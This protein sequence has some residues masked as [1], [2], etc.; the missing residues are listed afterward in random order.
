M[1]GDLVSRK[2]VI[3]ALT[4]LRTHDGMELSASIDYAEACEAI[5]DIPVVGATL[6][7]AE[8]KYLNTHTEPDGGY[9]VTSDLFPGLIGDGDTPNDAVDDFLEVLQDLRLQK[10]LTLD[11][12]KKERA[13]WLEMRNWNEKTDIMPML[14]LY[15]VNGVCYRAVYRDTDWMDERTLDLDYDG[16]GVDWICWARKPTDEERAAAKW[17]E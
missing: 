10:P 1:S 9:Y 6:R 4:S 11:E 3:D 12:V 5:C 17:E 16:Y 7:R 8:T 2:A 13:V 15:G 14:V